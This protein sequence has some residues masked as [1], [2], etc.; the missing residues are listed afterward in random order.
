MLDPLLFSIY[1]LS[2]KHGTHRHNID[3][4]CNV[5]DTQ[6]YVLIKCGATN[7]LMSCLAEI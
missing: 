5:Y 2:L 3:L 6:L 7:L 4:H 1:M